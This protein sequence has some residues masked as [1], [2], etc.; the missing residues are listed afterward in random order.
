VFPV[1]S[2]FQVRGL[3]PVTWTIIALCGLIALGQLGDTDNEAIF[4]YGAV[5]AL[6]VFDLFPLNADS[7]AVAFTCCRRCSCMPAYCTC[8]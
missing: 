6:V 7:P 4:L 2:E 1:S 5:R 8:C 3:T